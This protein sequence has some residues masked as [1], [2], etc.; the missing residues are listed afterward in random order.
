MILCLTAPCSCLLD[1][2]RLEAALAALPDWRQA[3][4]RARTSPEHRAARR[5]RL[6]AGG[7]GSPPV[8][9]LP[10]PFSSGPHLPRQ[11]LFSGP[12]PVF[13][14]PLPFRPPLPLPG[15]RRQP[16]A[17]LRSGAAPSPAPMGE[18]GRPVLPPLGVGLAAPAAAA[19][20]RLFPAVVRKGSG[21]QG[22]RRQGFPGE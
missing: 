14:Q 2:L 8:G 1:P 5:R 4:L 22:H 21:N 15:Q 11:T 3:Q 18:T 20:N 19:R 13:L 16:K 7:T 10:S 17:G 9:N 6:A 12:A